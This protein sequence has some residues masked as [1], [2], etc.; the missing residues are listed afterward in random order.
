[1]KSTTL[2]RSFLSNFGPFIRRRLALNRLIL[3]PQSNPV[4]NSVISVTEIFKVSVSVSVFIAIFQFQFSFSYSKFFS[5]SFSF[6]I[7]FSFSFI[8]VFQNFP[9]SVSV[10]DR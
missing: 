5:Y 4:L 3:D 9:F 2:Y 10:V 1:M 6:F 8:S 7:F